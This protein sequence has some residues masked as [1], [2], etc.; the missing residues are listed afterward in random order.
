MPLYLNNIA[1]LFLVERWN[2]IENV[3]RITCPTMFI[4]G[5]MDP[6]IPC[7]HSYE[8]YRACEASE[9]VLHVCPNVD[10]CS[11][12]E[13][14]DTINPIAAF[15]RAIYKRPKVCKISIDE[16]V[17]ICPKSVIEKHSER[18]NSA[19]AAMHD[20]KA[21]NQQISPRN[22]NPVPST[23]L[24]PSASSWSGGPVPVNSSSSTKHCGESPRILPQRVYQD[25]EPPNCFKYS[26][27]SSF[28]SWFSSS[29]TSD[30]SSRKDHH[31]RSRS[32]SSSRSADVSKNAF[33]KTLESRYGIVA[34]GPEGSL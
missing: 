24:P 31:S 21:S 8:L 15:L 27:P 19:I 3:P 25:K 18:I 22:R 5:E 34:G 12:H 1:P 7:K 33:L 23:M 28:M 9:K 26:I 4:H 30:S 17:F 14:E 11:F 6:L 29:T 10:H 16:S 32:R 13:P 2:S 20:K